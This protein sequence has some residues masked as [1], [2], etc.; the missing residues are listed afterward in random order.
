[1]FQKI[2]F[3]KIKGYSSVDEGKDKE[4]SAKEPERTEAELEE[5]LKNKR[6]QEEIKMDYL[7]IWTL[8]I[9]HLLGLMIQVRLNTQRTIWI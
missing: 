9:T 4:I 7:N 8:T 1:M 2:K 3:Q 5:E 6:A